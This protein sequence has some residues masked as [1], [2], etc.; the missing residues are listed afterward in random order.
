MDNFVSTFEK[1]MHLADLRQ[2][3]RQPQENLPNLNFEMKLSDKINK[4]SK[5]NGMTLLP[6]KCS[7]AEVYAIFLKLFFIYII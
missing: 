5:Y 2:F 1:P 6:M 4:K 7:S 3:L